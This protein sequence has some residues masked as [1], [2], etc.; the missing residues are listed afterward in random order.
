MFKNQIK[1]EFKTIYLA[2]KNIDS[3]IVNI[4][5]ALHTIEK[6]GINI[7]DLEKQLDNLGIEFYKLKQLVLDKKEEV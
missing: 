2:N 4:K 7:S 1:E 6:L 3:E 5:V